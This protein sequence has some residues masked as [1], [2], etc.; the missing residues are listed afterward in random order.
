M[1]AV[2]DIIGKQFSVTKDQKVT[3]D[4][5]NKEEG[6][7]ITF[8]RVL[9]IKKDDGSSVVGQPLV[10]GAKV[11]AKI[12]KNFKDKKV[13]ILKKRRRQNSRRKRGHRQQK[14]E[15]QIL[16]IKI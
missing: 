2:I 8:D 6:A 14:T 5:L 4:N 9:C 11:E 15:I 12:T 10:E 13:I 3:V 1:L 7:T 16:S